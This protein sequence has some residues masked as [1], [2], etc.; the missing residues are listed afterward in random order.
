MPEK[1]EMKYFKTY[2]DFYI[3]SSIHVALAVVSLCAVTM[4]NFRLQADFDLLGF[5]F[6]GAVTGYNFVKYAPIAKLHHRSLAKRLKFIQVFSLLS[7]FLLIWFAL[8]LEFK[9]LIWAAFFG[10]FTFLYAM[11]VFSKKRNLRS[12][13][14]IKIFIISFVWAGVTVILP[15]LNGNF[16]VGLDILLEFIQRFLFI[17]VLILPFEIRDLKYDLERLGTIPQKVGV[18]STKIIGSILLVTLLLLE[19][20]KSFT[21]T[22]AFGAL[23]LTV[24]VTA[25]F[26]WKA[27]E[28]QSPYFA[29]FW[30]EGIP[31]FW[32]LSLLLF[33]SF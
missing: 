10:L 23:L 1:T 18:T 29:S 7:F 13:S 16:S 6:F 15:V 8:Q 11:P 25:G 20:L 4:L 26:V 31:V 14:G 24:M 5:L 28:K 32:L 12:V 21:S 22:E 19:Y 9:I 3:N 33:K 30:V 27:K 2:F 17:L